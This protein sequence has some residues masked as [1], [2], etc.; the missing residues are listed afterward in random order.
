MVLGVA[1]K[2][3]GH[4]LEDQRVQ[5]QGKREPQSPLGI[6][7]MTRRFALVIGNAA[8]AH[9]G[10]LAN[11]RND[12]T[13]IADVLK[14]LD[15]KVALGTDLGRDQMEDV[16]IKFEGDIYKADAALFFFAGHGLQVKGQNYL[17][18]IDAEIKQRYICVVALSRLL[19]SW[20]RWSSRRGIP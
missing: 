5:S 18:P 11:P 16:L 19:R 10:E 15:F 17:I 9:A 12:A 14:V 20:E 7:T 2:P 3:F 6:I 8:Y 4:C 1:A 13:A